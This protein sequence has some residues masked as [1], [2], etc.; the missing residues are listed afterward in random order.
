[1]RRH[2]LR[3]LDA[4]R[5]PSYQSRRSTLRV[6]APPIPMTPQDMM[7]K[8]LEPGYEGDSELTFALQSEFHKGFPLE[9]LR[10]LLMSG[11]LHTQAAAAFLV[12]EI[13]PRLSFNMNCVVAEIADLLDSKIARI[14]FDAIEALLGCT[15]PADGAILGG[16]MLRLDD[17]HAGVRWRVTQFIALR[18][19]GSYGSRWKMP[20]R[21]A[22]NRR[23]RSF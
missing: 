1:M 11:N 14:R 22:R 23:S 7:S 2:L 13:S 8:L 17:E 20:P 10:P 21:C 5:T 3:F 15:T 9:N 4:G 18:N 19:A 12:A 6:D 16:V